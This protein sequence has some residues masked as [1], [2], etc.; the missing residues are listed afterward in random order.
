MII[1]IIFHEKNYKLADDLPARILLTIYMQRFKTF[2]QVCQFLYN[3]IIDQIIDMATM[4]K[5]KTQSIS[6]IKKKP[7][8][9]RP[10][11]FPGTKNSNF[12]KIKYQLPNFKQQCV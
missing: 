10:Q 9:Y 7:S 8:Q 5:D 12:L 2:R 11:T 6:P 3:T 1:T 4:F